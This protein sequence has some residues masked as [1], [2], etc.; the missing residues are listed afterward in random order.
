M[1][2]NTPDIFFE[3]FHFTACQ[4]I[5][6]FIIFDKKMKTFHKWTIM[7]ENGPTCTFKWF[8]GKSFFAIL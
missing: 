2:F 3:N 1:V 5:A 8:K 6:I 4:K 7:A